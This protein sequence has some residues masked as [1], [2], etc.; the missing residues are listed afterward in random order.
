[1]EGIMNR[2]EFLQMA[3]AAGVA[4]FAGLLHGQQPVRRLLLGVMSDL[5]NAGKLKDIG[6]DFIEGTVAGFLHPELDEKEFAP[7]LDNLRSCVLPVRSCSGLFPKQFRLTGPA[8]KH[9]EALEYAVKVCKRADA[10]GIP[11]IVL[12]SSG[13]RNLPEGFDPAQGRA[14]LIGFC[15]KLGDLIKDCK[16]TIALE[17]L[18]KKETNLL[19]TVA[20]GIEYVDSV[21]RPKIRLLADLYHMRLEGEVPD[22]IRK[23]GKRLLHCHVSEMDGRAAPGTKGDDFRAYLKALKDIGYAG[24]LSC[25]CRWPKSDPE[26]AWRKAL[27]TLRAQ[28]EP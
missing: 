12:G 8:A 5:D 6:Y 28:M 16:V 22:V 24:G 26:G 15:R 14:Q 23:A 2:R 13:A 7:Q 18:N 21:D 19:N 10:A 9:E 17:P 27:V 25:E 1:M 20:E 4:G 11:V 3:A